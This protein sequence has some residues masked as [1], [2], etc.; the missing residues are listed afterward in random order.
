MSK[1]G[2]LTK[3]NNHNSDIKV[4]LMNYITDKNN[5]N[6]NIKIPSNTIEIIKILIKNT[7]NEFDIISKNLQK[8]IEDNK[9]DF[10]DVPE[11]ILL[12]ENI[13]TIIVR[14]R[15][16]LEPFNGQTLAITSGEILKIII[17]LLIEMEQFS[18]SK[19][20]HIDIEDNQDNDNTFDS[21][22]DEKNKLIENSNNIIDVCVKLIMIPI[23]NDCNIA[24][25][26]F[27]CC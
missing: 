8:I 23:G 19:F 15:K 20:I 2:L 12:V 27:S 26:I 10:K 4:L 21:K 22:K 11:F 7:S 1:S 16:K 3:P 5:N 14:H 24:R 6:N 25:K 17:K 13:Y 18:L 9:I